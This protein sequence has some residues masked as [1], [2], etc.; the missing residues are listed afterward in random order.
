MLLKE[1]QFYIV[2]NPKPDSGW[3]DFEENEP[4][5][6]LWHVRDPHEVEAILFFETIVRNPNFHFLV[7]S[8]GDI[9]FD[10]EEVITAGY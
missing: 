8:Y 4:V 6:F 7:K 10:L 3:P 9:V 1:N 2:R 5:R